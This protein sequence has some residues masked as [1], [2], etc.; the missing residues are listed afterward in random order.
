MKSHH[1]LRL[2][3]VSDICSKTTIMK[4]FTTFLFI[5]LTF[6][7]FA[8]DIINLYS[9]NGTGGFA[10]DGGAAI[11]AQLRLPSDIYLDPS[12]VKYIADANNHCIRK[13]MANGIISTVAGTG[14]TSGFSGDGGLA[15]AARLNQPG[16]V[17]LDGSGNM[18]I[19]DAT[20]HRIRKV[21]GATGIITTIAGTGTATYT[22]DGGLATAA[23]INFPYGIALDNAGN[24]YI[25]E[26]SSSVIRKITVSTGII[27]TYAGTGT[28]GSTGDGGAATAARLN[29]PRDICIDASN[30][31]YIAD[32]VSNKVRKI[33][34]ATGI[35]TTIAGTGTAGSTGDGGAA[36]AARLRSPFGVTLDALG[37]IYIA[38]ATNNKIRKITASTGII[39]TFAG[40]GTGGYSGDGGDATLA[41]LNFPTNV[42][43]DASYLYVVDNSNNR[44][45]RIALVPIGLPVTFGSFTATV[46]PEKNVDLVWSTSSEAGN[47]YFSIESSSNGSDWKELLVV[48]AVGTTDQKQT[49]RGIDENPFVGIS[50][51][52]LIQVDQNGEK[53]LV[54]IEAVEIAGDFTLFPNPAESDYVTLLLP[55]KTEGE[56]FVE[57]IDVSGKIIKSEV[58]NIDKNHPETTIGI[59]EI[60]PGTYILQ[61]KSDM[62]GPVRKE[63]VVF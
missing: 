43:A 21:D 3:R 22:G 56:L 14:G 9:G 11:S 47:D 34:A 36:T 12:G 40:T 48:D 45:R 7:F 54:S 62:Q 19:A 59:Q 13:V 1:C 57:W 26:S 60:L 8:Q 15:T 5:F 28:S 52:R 32:R 20:N 25:S 10:G 55:S 46:T 44:V 38:D 23:T 24:I 42:F 33:T 35:I 39:S 18:Y 4:I 2:K 27:T 37:N 30:N 16:A 50:Y 61:I 63:I 41:R 29:F 49:Y 31:L 58:I 51:Y 53:N 6:T 17:C